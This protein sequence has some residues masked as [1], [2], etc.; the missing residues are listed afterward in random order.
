MKTSSGRSASFT[1]FQPVAAIAKHYLASQRF[2]SLSPHERKYHQSAIRRVL[3]QHGIRTY[4]IERRRR[5]RVAVV[6]H[7]GWNITLTFPSSPQISLVLVDPKPTC[8]G[9]CGGRQRGSHR[10]KRCD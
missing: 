3:A 5:H 9:R 4:R 7:G 10:T 6:A 1:S 8:A 2:R